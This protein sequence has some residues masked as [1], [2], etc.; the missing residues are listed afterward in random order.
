M[1]FVKS[2]YF[3]I[4]IFLV[5]FVFRV[6]IFFNSSILAFVLLLPVSLSSYGQFRINIKRLFVEDNKLIRLIAILF[7]IIIF[8]FLLPVFHGTYDFSILVPLVNQLVNILIVIL[9]VVLSY[10]KGNYYEVLDL[11]SYGFVLQSIIMFM[12]LLSPSIYN[13]VQ[14]TQDQG[15]IELSISQYGGYRN[16]GI[17]SSQFFYMNAAFGLMV[18]IQMFLYVS[19][20][21]TKYL[22]MFIITLFGLFVTGRSAL[23]GVFFAFVIFF[24]DLFQRNKMGFIFKLPLY[25]FICLLLLLVFYNYLPDFLR[26]WVFEAFI[27]YEKSGKLSSSSSDKL[28][29]E[30]FF[31][32]NPFTVIFGDGLYQNPLGE[33]Y[34][35]KT[36]SGYMRMILFYGIGGVIMYFLYFKNIMKYLYS[37]L[38]EVEIYKIHNL[39][40][41]IALISLYVII[42]HVKGEIMGFLISV[43]IILFI[44]LICTVLF[45]KELKVKV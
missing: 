42:L 32:P 9:F 27:N 5:L 24:Y 44:W 7:L 39:K 40:L 34:Y 25:L 30:M 15:A 28:L 29:N 43:Q 33:G 21:K 10:S 18:I 45:N 4:C 37:N 38:K 36:D 2:V 26:N 23:L 6:P 22:F 31:M 13:L 41:L 1:G 3:T 8:S 20:R 17:G 14:L 35:G 11:V 19:L 16:L 12:S